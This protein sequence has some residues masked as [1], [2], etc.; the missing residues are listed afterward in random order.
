MGIWFS[1]KVT[2]WF[3]EVTTE[4]FFEVAMESL[5]ESTTTEFRSDALTDWAIR[6]WVQLALRANFGQL[7]QFHHLF[8]VK[9]HFGCG[10][11][12]SPRL[13]WL[14]F[15]WGNRMSVAEWMIHMVFTTEGF[16]ELTIGFLS[17][18]L[19]ATHRIAEKGRG[20][21]LFS[22]STT[23]S[24]SRTFRHLFAYKISFHMRWLSHIFNYIACIYQA[25]ATREDLP[26]YRI[27]I[28]L[29]DDVMLIFLISLMI[30]L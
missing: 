25:A 16:F 6:S 17:R 26:P 20:L 11:R 10:L 15:S 24:C 9:F 18:T 28:W 1:F 21:Y 23:S 13:I 29:I 12:Q 14:R 7:F 8:S 27:T 2:E 19:R 22:H 30:W 3:F 5:Y 4:C